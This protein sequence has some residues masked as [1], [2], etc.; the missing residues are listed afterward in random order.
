MAKVSLPILSPKCSVLPPESYV[1]SFLYIL[2]EMVY[3]YVSEDIY[4]SPFTYSNDRILHTLFFLYF[5]FLSMQQYILEIIL[6]NI[7]S[8]QF[9]FY[10]RIVF[11]FIE[12]QRFI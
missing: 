1:T 9:L 8:F 12:L 4:N 10:S 11:H 2:P 3:L 6:Q 7:K 5:A